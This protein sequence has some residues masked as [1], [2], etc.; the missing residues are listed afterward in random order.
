[1]VEVRGKLLGDEIGTDA[2]G[3]LDP[4]RLE[5]AD[6]IASDVTVGITDPDDDPSDA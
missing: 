4:C 3:D 5:R 1:M 6:A 2:D